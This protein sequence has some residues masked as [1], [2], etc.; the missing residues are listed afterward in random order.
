MSWVRV[1]TSLRSTAGSLIDFP[2]RSNIGSL[3]ESTKLAVSE[4]V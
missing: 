3:S 4:G 1:Q 2:N